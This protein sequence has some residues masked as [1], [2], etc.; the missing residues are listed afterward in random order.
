MVIRPYQHRDLESV[1]TCFRY[2]VQEIG[3]RY[4][5]SDQT[6]TWAPS[7]PDRRFWAKRLDSGGVFVAE[8]G[9]D[10]AGFVRVEKTGLVDLLYVDPKFERKGIGK[11]LLKKAC[12]WAAINGAD[13]LW[14][15]VS[16]AARPLFESMGFEVEEELVVERKGVFF[17][18][19]RM[20]RSGDLGNEKEL[21]AISDSRK[22]ID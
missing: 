8:I 1:L 5:T 3:A 7:S 16:I 4:Y 10:L 22:S 20:N 19:Y 6:K 11:K 15:N 9:N 21:S 12:H 18:N 13:K 14:S 2:S 17:K